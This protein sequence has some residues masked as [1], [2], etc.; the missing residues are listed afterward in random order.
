MRLLTILTLAVVVT[1]VVGLAF[2][3]A[4]PARQ[5]APLM[6]GEPVFCPVEGVNKVLTL[7]PN[8]KRV[9]AGD[10]VCE[11]DSAPLKDRLA[12]QLIAVQRARADYQNAVL[13]REVAEIAVKESEEVGRLDRETLKDSADLME[14]ELGLK[15]LILDD[16]KKKKAAAVEQKRAELDVKKAGQRLSQVTRDREKL[17]KDTIPKQTKELQ[18]GVQEASAVENERKEAL[19]LATAMAEKTR[20]QIALCKILRQRPD[21]WNFHDGRLVESP[22]AARRSRRGETS[23]IDSSCSASTPRDPRRSKTAGMVLWAI[24]LAG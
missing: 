8:G 7:V 4:P 20:K 6:P 14:K 21:G 9:R 15:R 23:G 2:S 17:E 12:N 1:G 16:L 3:Q 22:K 19:D 24:G 10:L 18:A 5:G 13:T 11:L